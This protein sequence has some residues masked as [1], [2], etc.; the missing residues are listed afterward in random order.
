MIWALSSAGY[1]SRL[2][3]VGTDWL[4]ISVESSTSYSS[5]TENQYYDLLEGLGPAWTPSTDEN[6]DD[7]SVASSFDYGGPC[8]PT[9]IAGNIDPLQDSE[10]ANESEGINEHEAMSITSRQEL[11][12]ICSMSFAVVLLLMQI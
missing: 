12:S 4:S 9:F 10:G 3:N 7:S 5:R 11:S 6:M 1:L 2:H 8:K